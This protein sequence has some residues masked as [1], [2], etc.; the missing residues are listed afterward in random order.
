MYGTTST[1]SAAYIIGGG[2]YGRNG[3]FGK[4]SRIAEYRNGEWR[5]IGRLSMFKREISSI[6]YGDEV[7]IIG[8]NVKS[9][10]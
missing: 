7:M 2:I 9:D 4:A 6:S 8:G 5:N 3:V 10:R 1:A